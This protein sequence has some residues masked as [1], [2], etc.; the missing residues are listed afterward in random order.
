MMESFDWER[1]GD[2]ALGRENLGTEMPVIVYRLLQYTMRD[3]LVARYGEG[4]AT[5]VLRNAGY[6]AGISFCRNVIKERGS[7][8][9]FIADVQKQLKRLKIGIFRVEKA[10]INNMKFVLTVSEDLDCSGLPVSGDTVCDY[11]E[12]FISGILQEF[13]GQRF[14]VQEVDCWAT[15]DRTCRF[16]A[17]RI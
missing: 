2:I 10:D 5:E 8:N 1:L 6:R 9:S 14:A 11:D 16:V 15:G 17:D 3:E 12:G 7:F 13:T 4:V